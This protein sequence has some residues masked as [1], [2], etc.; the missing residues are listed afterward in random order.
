MFVLFFERSVSGHILKGSEIPF[1]NYL[2]VYLLISSPASLVEYIYLVRKQGKAMLVYGVVSY[3]LMF[4][5]VV[6]PP[7]LGSGIEYCMA[8]LV[9]QSIFRMV[10]L[11]I[12]LFRFSNPE[13]DFTFIRKHLKSSYPLIFSM[14]LSGSVQ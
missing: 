3:A 6:L 2:I 9:I 8:G 11:L 13:F 7:L 1:L 4:L 10:W 5:L 14:L 12:L